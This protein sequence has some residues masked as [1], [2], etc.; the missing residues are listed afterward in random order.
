[1][2]KMKTFCWTLALHGI[3]VSGAVIERRQLAG[4]YGGTVTAPSKVIDVT[5]RVRPDAKR[6]KLLFGPFE[7]PA[8]N[9]NSPAGHSHGTVLDQLNKPMDPNGFILSLTVK[10]GVCGDC[11]VLAGKSDITFEDG[12]RAGIENGVYLHHILSTLSL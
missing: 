7:M 5:P 12:S 8:I 10:E 9:P 3:L 11:T 6:Q 4:L 2:I 1:M